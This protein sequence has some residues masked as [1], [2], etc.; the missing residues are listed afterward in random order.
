MKKY[1][2]A[3]IAVAISLPTIAQNK[4]LSALFNYATYYIPDDN[5]PY[6]EAI[7]SIDAWSL[8][9]NE[10][11][12]GKYSATVEVT[13]I[14]KSGDSVCYLKK[15]N[16]N[17]PTVT[18]T[19]NLGFNIIDIQRFS[20]RNGIYTLSVSMR[21]LA[22]TAAASTAEEKVVVFYENER[23]SIS[24]LQLISSAKKTTTENAISR[25]GYDMEPYINDFLPEQ[26]KQI[27]FYYE[28]YNLETELGRDKFITCAY[29][30]EYETG[31]RATDI[32]ATTRHQ[33]A[34]TVPVFGTIDIANLPSG[35]YNIVVEAR[36]RDNETLIYT[37]LPFFRSNP[38]VE[39]EP[40]SDYAA[41]FV[42]QFTDT[43]TLNIY[44]D[45]LTPIASEI[46]RS[47]ARKVI[48]SNS[49]EKKQAFFYSFWA[50][51]NA[52]APSKA[53]EEYKVLVDYVLK[54]FSY[55]KT[56]GHHTD[57]GRVYLQ[58]GP[59]DF[60]RDEKNFVGTSTS[61]GSGEMFSQDYEGSL[62]HIYYLP[63]QLWRYNSLPAD[64]PNRVFIF[65]DQ[66]RS[67]YYKLLNSNAKGEVRDMKWE[68]VLSNGQLH[69]NAIG[70]VGRQFERGY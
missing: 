35:H 4:S 50:K 40:L 2:F 56:P 34:Q 7:L 23:P 46:E 31:I 64:Q 45:A 17:S 13:L 41:T 62:G 53:W 15:Y 54:E 52:T 29:V 20:L 8:N 6:V 49:I 68:Q 60:V 16:L 51:R 69:E 12:I 42:A 14:A 55:P 1:L 30:E 33:A 24:M 32:L 63:Y 9:F 3:L 43:N 25:R 5:R 18:D 10:V 44:I 38:G 57:R 47:Q 19:N 21:D 27:S 22:S 39:P 58:Y 59:P 11:E 48:A 26:I 61:Q 36:D 65:W 37:K 28:L 67:G 66:F 70:E